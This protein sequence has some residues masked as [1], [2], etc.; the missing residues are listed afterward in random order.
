MRVSKGGSH[1]TATTAIC[2]KGPERSRANRQYM[3]TKLPAAWSFRMPAEAGIS[4]WP[5]T[6]PSI[7]FVAHAIDKRY[8]AWNYQLMFTI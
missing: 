2:P 8:T 5:M 7:M 6:T 4:Y 1:A 3:Y